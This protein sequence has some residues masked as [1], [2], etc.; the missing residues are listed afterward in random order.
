MDARADTTPDREGYDLG[1]PVPAH[2]PVWAQPIY[3][4]WAFFTSLAAVLLM[5][6][7]LQLLS[8]LLIYYLLVA[9]VLV[10]MCVAVP[11]RVP[12]AAQSLW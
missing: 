5:L 4:V 6:L 12:A 10:N 1:G 7:P 2:D 9:I 11:V 3:T 8:L